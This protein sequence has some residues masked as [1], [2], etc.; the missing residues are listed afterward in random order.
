MNN[1]INGHYGSYYSV[2]RP[3]HVT[4]ALYR[5]VVTRVRTVVYFL[6]TY[7]KAT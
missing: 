3:R 1:N 7:M 2:G 5:N 4:V 6:N